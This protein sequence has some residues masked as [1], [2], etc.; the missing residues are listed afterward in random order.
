MKKIVSLNVKAAFLRKLMFLFKAGIGLLIV[1]PLFLGLGMSFMNPAEMSAVPLHIIPRTPVVYTYAKVLETI[2]VFRFLLNSFITCALVI[3][4]QII[5]SSF[6]AY[7][8][9]FFRFR[10][11]K[12]LS[13][14]VLATIMI[15]GDAIIIANYLTISRFR[16]NDTY[17]ALAAPYLA[18]AMGIFL[19]RQFFLTIPK[20]LHEA[21]ILDGCR[22]L[23]FLLSVVMP[24]SKPAAAS[25]G[26]YIFIN[27][28]NQF[29]WPLLVTNSDRMRTIQVGM[30]LLRDAERSDDYG[31]IM[32][33]AMMTLIP[34][35][36]AFIMG[37][38][39][40]VKGMTAGAI[41]G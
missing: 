30:S 1:S 29:F 17:A 6:G 37:Q 8:F 35:V 10:G 39:H 19:M 23:R 38:K 36:F 12:L 27:V 18:S 14:A 5:T 31:V 7:A 20:E 2:P 32:A 15:P 21:A 26:I 24:I 11:Q 22:D 16:L 9:S 13:M 33:G 40:M 28:Y 25:L 3:T 4:G 41:K 34:A